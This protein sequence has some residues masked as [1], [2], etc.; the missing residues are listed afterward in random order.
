M[1]FLTDGGVFIED[2]TQAYIDLERGKM[3]GTNCPTSSNA[4]CV[5][6]Y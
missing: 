6:R 4:T 5:I 2:Q 3:S 1:K